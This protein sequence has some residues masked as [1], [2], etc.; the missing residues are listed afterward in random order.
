[1]GM[2]SCSNSNANM[3]TDEVGKIH[4]DYFANRE[5]AGSPAAVDGG[6]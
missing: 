1:M 2:P 4:V 3:N 5:S 6:L